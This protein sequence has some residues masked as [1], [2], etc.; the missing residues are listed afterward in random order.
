VRAAYWYTPAAAVADPTGVA[1]FPDDQMEPLRRLV[2]PV[3][4]ITHWTEF[5][6]SGHFPR[7]EQPTALPAD[8]RA[9]FP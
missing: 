8:I 9:F 2:E 6:R 7:M 3:N 4:N 1:V 5:D